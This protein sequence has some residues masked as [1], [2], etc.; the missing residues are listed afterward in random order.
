MLEEETGGVQP[1]A[2]ECQQ[3]LEAGRGKQQILPWSFQK[4]PALLSLVCSSVNLTL[5]FCH[6]QL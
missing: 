1:Q 4:K 6:L 2:K 3:L 5:D